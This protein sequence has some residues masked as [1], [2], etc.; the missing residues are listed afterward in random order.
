MRLLMAELLLALQ[1]PGA[2]PDDL[3]ASLKD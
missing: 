1:A 2:T 3:L